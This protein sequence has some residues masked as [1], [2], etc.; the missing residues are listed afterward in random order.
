MHVKLI[1]TC[2][3]NKNNNTAKP[4]HNEIT[5]KIDCYKH[6]DESEKL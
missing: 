2:I 1:I 6:H 5:E 3:N 4:D